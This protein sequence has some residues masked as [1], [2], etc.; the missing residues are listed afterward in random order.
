LDA[1]FSPYQTKL[2]NFQDKPLGELSAAS[3]F[4]AEFPKSASFVVRRL[5]KRG[6]Q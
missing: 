3:N 1:L 6:R 2:A 5:A 4:Q